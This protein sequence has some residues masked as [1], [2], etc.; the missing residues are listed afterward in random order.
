MSQSKFQETG[1]VKEEKLLLR[2]WLLL[3]VLSLLTIF[4]LAG[5]IEAI[6]R[7]IYPQYGV[8]AEE[9]IVFNDP[10]TGSRGIPNSVCTGKSAEGELTE[11]HFNSSGFRADEDF[12]PKQP[13]T[14]RIVMIG[15]S[16]VFGEWVPREKTFAALLP[17]EL[18]RRTGLKVELYNEAMGFRLPD[19][20]AL[21]FNEVL[22]AKPDLVLWPVVT[23]DLKTQAQVK[24][25]TP[26]HDVALHR[27]LPVKAWYRIKDAFA[28]KSLRSAIYEIFKHTRS[29]T[30]LSQVMYRSKSQYIKS[31]IMDTDYEVGYLKANP[32]P[33]WQ[34]RLD[35]FSRNDALIE[36]QA[37][38]AG[39]PLVVVLLP[40]HALSAMI[41]SGEWPAGYDPYKLDD[42]LRSIVTSHGGTY[43]DMLADLRTVSDPDQGY[44]PFE[45]H[46]NARGHAIFSGLLANEL[47]SGPVPALNTTYKSSTIST[48]RGK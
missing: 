36:A 44:F 41:A 10:S 15:T 38:A 22:K 6:A 37:R 35:D 42:E 11:Y 14:Y 31:S 26:T 33:D 47:V 39:V 9:C 40:N 12:G 13:G 29:A 28:N 27:S 16:F 19:T 2:D 8:R 20:L 32:S 5:S 3:P 24:E 34:K 21:H 1:N 25:D 45:G 46:P 43:I 7:L 18:S 48:E 17:L 4:V 30:L 23:G